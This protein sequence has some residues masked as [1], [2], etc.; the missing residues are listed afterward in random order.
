MP[1]LAGGAGACVQELCWSKDNDASD[2]LA[3][4]CCVSAAGGRGGSQ[5]AVHADEADHRQ[6]RRAGTAAA[7]LDG[8]PHAQLCRRSAPATARLAAQGCRGSHAAHRAPG[9]GFGTA[10]RSCPRRPRTADENSET[11]RAIQR[12][13][14]QRGYGAWSSDGVMR[15]VTRAAI[16]AYEHDQ[17]LPLTGEASEAL[18]KRCCSASR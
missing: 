14:R 17:G 2:R 12:E 1:A 6:P 11:I 16:M 18:L 9:A 7:A 5:R 4:R 3:S 15:P 8:G 13:L 10:R